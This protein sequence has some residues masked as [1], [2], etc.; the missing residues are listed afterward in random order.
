MGIVDEIFLEV[1]REGKDMAHI[2]QI[3]ISNGGVPKYPVPQAKITSLGVEGD[4]HKNTKE[5]GG[6]ARALCLYSLEH[7]LAFQAEGNSIFPGAM[8]EN[9]TLAGLDWSSISPGD[10]IYLGEEVIIEISKH[11]TP[12]NNIKS[13]FSDGNYSRVSEKANPG[14]A[15]FYARVIKPGSIQIGDKVFHKHKKEDVDA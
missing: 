15:R 2:F 9:L 12:C 6:E 11:T 3:N 4:Q 14:W 8:G 5:H 13:F 7:I 10:K 1:Q